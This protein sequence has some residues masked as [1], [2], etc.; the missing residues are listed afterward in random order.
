MLFRTKAFGL[1]KRPAQASWSNLQYEQL[2]SDSPPSY[3]D[4]YK[5]LNF[6]PKYTTAEISYTFGVP[7]FPLPSSASATSNKVLIIHATS[8]KLFI[9][10][11]YYHYRIVMSM[12]IIVFL[13]KYYI[14]H[15]HMV[16]ACHPT[17]FR[18]IL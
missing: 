18:Y 5:A 12:N 16:L 9:F 3:D 4:S 13:E 1:E 7:S 17:L 6:I 11:T 15:Q 10:V 14:S 8:I 2:Y